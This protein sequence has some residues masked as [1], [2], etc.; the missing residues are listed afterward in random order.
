MITTATICTVAVSVSPHPFVL[1]LRYLMRALYLTFMLSN[2]VSVF[3]HSGWLEQGHEICHAAWVERIRHPT[4]LA[5][6]VDEVTSF[7]T[8]QVTS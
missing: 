5:S 6:Y 4:C 8:R 2:N 7:G 1:F 3:L